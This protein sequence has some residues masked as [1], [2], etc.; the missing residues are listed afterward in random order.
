MT[1]GTAGPADGVAVVSASDVNAAE[2]NRLAAR[3]GI[4][5]RLISERTHSLEDVFFRLTGTEA[6]MSPGQE[7]GAIR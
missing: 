6:A 5:L 1:A 4:T 3:H 7:M 2:L